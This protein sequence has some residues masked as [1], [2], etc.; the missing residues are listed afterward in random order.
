MTSPGTPADT[1]AYIVE[2]LVG[3][4]GEPE[5]VV[6]SGRALAERTVSGMA[7][8]FGD[9]FGVSPTIELATVEL[10]RF[11]AARPDPADGHA[12]SVV[13][14]ASSPDAMLLLLDPPAIALLVSL[15]FGGDP[16]LPVAPIDRPL[17][18][19]EM[20]VATSALSVVAEVFNGTGPRAFDVKLP[21]A[22]VM[23]GIDLARHVLRDG[24]AVR[25]DFTLSTKASKGRL[26]V[27]MP[28]RVLL[29]HR[30]EGGRAD[31]QQADEWRARFNEEVM[32][33]AVAIEATMPLARLTLGRIS[34]FREGDLIE[35]DAD[36][37]S[38]ARLSA[39]GQTLFVCEFG[40]L[41]QN[42]TVRVSHPFD[43]GQEFIDELMPS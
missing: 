3:D 21:L 40:R 41:G 38:R 8:G 16:D 4:T 35:L 11:A 33:S 12:M 24:P 39:R 15:L 20:E 17:S 36:A 23:T 19:T 18:P 14:S 37:A 28:Q 22:P 27:H 13:A 30:G 31:A 1:R 9:A 5:H 2:R 29:K 6:A 32:R 42:Y 43:A 26:A 25:M 34:E 10:A 7:T